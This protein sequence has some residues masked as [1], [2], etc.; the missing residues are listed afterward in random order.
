MRFKHFMKIIEITDKKKWDGF[1]GEQ[2]FSQFLQSW[3]WGE[4]HE[5]MGR[6][7]WR[8]AVVDID[9]KIDM[10]SGDSI[11]R[12][13]GDEEILLAAQIIKYHLPL[14]QSYLYAPRGPIINQKPGAKSQRLM[15]LFSKEIKHL[16]K[17]QKSIFFRFEPI[18]NIQHDSSI[19]KVES[20]QPEEDWYL[21]LEKTEEELLKEM[22]SKT[23][24]NIKVALKKGIDIKYDENG[25][26]FDDFWKLISNTYG[27]KEIRTHAKEYY[28]KILNQKERVK[29]W[30]ARYEEK[31]IAANILSYFGDTVIYLHGGADY[32]FRNLM[33]PYLLQ[34]KAI[35]GAKEK[36]YKYYN[37]GGISE[38]NKNWAGISRFKKGFG[39]L[40]VH[41]AGT[42]DLEIKK[43]RYQLYRIIK[44]IKSI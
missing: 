27:R 17:S 14:G 18:E 44:K 38:I 20:I 41:Y 26:Y 30:V 11:S 7:I 25:K 40:G 19:Y 28:Q 35:L 24:Y 9:D 32:Q 29:L 10:P 43:G 22:H 16:A 31:I 33:A 2:P 4:F 21:N 6:K 3:D 15:K 12:T 1:I 37:F 42:Y 36:G 39:G 5:R 34:W 23:R 8:L 13:F